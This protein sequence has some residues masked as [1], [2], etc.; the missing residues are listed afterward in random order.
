LFMEIVPI[1]VSTMGFL[2]AIAIIVE[3]L[4]P[5]DP[6]CTCFGGQNSGGRTRR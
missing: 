3:S 4:E 6:T 5:G 2:A 1:N